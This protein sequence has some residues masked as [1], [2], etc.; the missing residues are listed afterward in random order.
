MEA[1]RQSTGS[2]R[3]I[4]TVCLTRRSQSMK[5]MVHSTVR[6]CRKIVSPGGIRLVMVEAC[7]SNREWREIIQIPLGARADR[8]GIVL[9]RGQARKACNGDHRCVVGAKFDA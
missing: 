5:P 9:S 8:Q 2:S 7:Y 1:P 4:T 3:S 6:P